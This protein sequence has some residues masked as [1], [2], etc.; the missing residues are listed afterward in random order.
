MK[1]HRINL[2]ARFDLLVNNGGFRFVCAGDSIQ[3]AQDV[4]PWRC[5]PYSW[6]VYR[7]FSVARVVG[8]YLRQLP[9]VSK[10]ERFYQALTF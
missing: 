5:W 2:G 6:Q 3:N 1:T 8:E 10:L 4:Q 9:E 7:E